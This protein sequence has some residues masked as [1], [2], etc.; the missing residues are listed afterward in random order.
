MDRQDRPLRGG[1]RQRHTRRK[2]GPQSHEAT[3]RA[4]VRETKLVGPPNETAGGFF[5]RLTNH[6]GG[7]SARSGYGL[8]GA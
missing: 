7:S 2:P 5:G 1:S 8:T 6:P 3:V 4:L